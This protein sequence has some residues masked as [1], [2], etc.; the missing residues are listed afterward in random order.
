MSANLT[1]VANPQ[2]ATTMLD[3]GGLIKVL[4]TG[5]GIVYI[6]SQNGTDCTPSGTGVLTTIAQDALLGMHSV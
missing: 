4:L 2:S 6:A 1:N 3:E 5:D